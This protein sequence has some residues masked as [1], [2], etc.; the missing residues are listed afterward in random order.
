[1]NYI[2]IS[3]YILIALSFAIGIKIAPR[4]QINKDSFSMDAMTSLKGIMALFVL[5]HHLSQKK[6]FQ[7]THTISLF[8]FVGFL[9][10]GVFF[11]CSGYGLYK[12]YV[13]KDN[14]LKGF[15][16][17]RILPIVIYYYV[18]IAIYTV[19]HVIT[20]NAF[21]L[22]EWLFKLSGLV[23]IN[24]Q[25]WFIPVIIIM[26]LAFYIVFKNDKLRKYGI[27]MLLGVTIF[28]GILFCILN[29]FPWYLGDSSG[30]WMEEGALNNLPWWRRFCAL[31][32][33]GEW[34][35]NSTIGFV[36]G[37]TI[38]KYEDFF[39]DFIASKIIQISICVLFIIFT[40]LGMYCLWNVGYWT[41]F[42]G[43]LG[44]F[45]KLTCYAVQCFQ[46]VFTDLFIVLLMRKVY[47][48]N[49]L[50]SFLGKR[51]L[52]LYLM[53]EIALFSW[54]FLIELDGKPLVMPHNWNA[55]VY[56][57]LVTA[58]VLVSA[59]IYNLINRTITKP[60]KK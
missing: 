35:V 25:A 30:W 46:V 29:H 23:L 9:F 56:L 20:G 55:L 33:E 41:E 16:K 7:E 49:R 59:I 8:E 14:Y 60:L 51:T 32:F 54:L 21:T 13:I 39:L 38:A 15:L 2:S 31:P 53:Q 19:Y 52:E 5:F 44:F 11:F 4:N 18:M 57:L 26:Y 17:R 47:V 43:K 3:I 50:Y 34:W 48:N 24:S 58:T 12:S 40:L 37:I 36:L 1:M 42:S 6:L 45:N 27:P 28:Q 22:S 10:V